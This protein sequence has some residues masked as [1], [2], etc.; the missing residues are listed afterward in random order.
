MLT[1]RFFRTKNEAEVTF[2]FVCNKN[3][4]VE[5]L[6]EFNNWQPQ[7]MKYHKKDRVFRTKVRLPKDNSFQFRYLVNKNSWQNDHHADKYQL[8]C[9]GSDNSIVST[10]QA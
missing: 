2:E 7:T 3:D 4:D 8:N 9:F 10:F 6:G 5:L 1:K